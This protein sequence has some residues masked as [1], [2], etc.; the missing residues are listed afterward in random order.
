MTNSEALG[1]EF[2]TERQRWELA[3]DAAAVAAFDADVTT[4]AVHWD[5][6][7]RTLWGLGPEEA[8]EPHLDTAFDRVHPEDRGELQAAVAQAIEQ[9]GSYRLEFR[10][11]WPDG[12]IRWVSGTGRALAGEDGRAVRLLGTAQDVTAVRTARDEAARLVDSMQ[13][14]FASFDR[15]WRIT[16]VNASGANIAGR[17]ANELIGRVLWEEFPGLD[18]LQFGREYRRAME[19]GE[20]VDIEAYYPHLD[21]WFEVRC[22]PTAEGLSQYFTDITRRHHDQ[23]AAHAAA[24]NLRLLARVGELLLENDI[25]VAI[26]NLAAAVVPELADWT[27][28]TVRDTQGTFHDLGRAH[29]DP[30]MRPALDAFATHIMTA[31]TDRSAISIVT[32]TGEALLLQDYARTML[33]QTLSDEAIRDLARPLHADAILTVPIT[34]RQS[35]LGAISLVRI[36]GKPLWTPEQT[37]I[38]LEIGRR[39]GIALENAH[40]TRAQQR[41][42]E[43]LQNS[44]L[45]TPSQPQDIQVVVRYQAAARD[46]AVGGDWYDSFLLRD[47]ATTLVVG[48]VSGHNRDAAAAMGQVRALLRGTAYALS[49]PPAHVLTAL[50]EAML[51]LNVGSLATCVLAQIE[52]TNQQRRDGYRML[53]WSNAGHPPPI[54][55]LHD[56]EPVILRTPADLLLGLDPTSPRS[57]HTAKLPDGAVLILYTDGLVEHRGEDIDQGLEHLAD[58]LRQL[59]SLPLDELCAALLNRLAKNADDDVVILAARLNPQHHTPPRD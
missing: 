54:L 3:L 23:E 46:A 6:R 47:G 55:M 37:D 27:L 48:D 11:I 38:A 14:G 41:M 33:Q 21:A 29:T 25:A 1:Q 15:D 4:G 9:C 57:D 2:A 52:Q 53:R 26:S 28:V 51:G 16:Y 18:E 36:P 30:A 32:R 43:T 24:A 44:L 5:K 45:S 31:L 59:R 34:G 40:L 10:I 17:V 56:Q 58:T 42:S 50:D 35:T 8:F 20:V 7:M 12:T 49:R 39:A 13:T 22:V 19:T